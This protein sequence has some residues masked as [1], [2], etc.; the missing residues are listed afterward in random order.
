MLFQVFIN[1]IFDL[2]RDVEYVEPLKE[3]ANVFGNPPRKLLARE[4][5]CFLSEGS[6]RAFGGKKNNDGEKVPGHQLQV[7]QPFFNLSHPLVERVLRHGTSLPR[8]F[9]PRRSYSFRSEL[10]RLEKRGLEVRG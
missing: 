1:K 8:A 6:D 3:L 9:A 2:A 4:L 5:H 10:E 7:T